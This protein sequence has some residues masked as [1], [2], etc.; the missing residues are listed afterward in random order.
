MNGLERI[1]GALNDAQVEGELWLDGSY[2]TEK[3]EPEDV[4]IVLRIRGEFYDEATPDQQAVIDLVSANLK[5]SL[6]CDSYVFV[7][8]EEPH[9]LHEDGRK[10]HDYWLRQW[11]QD[12]SGAPKGMAILTLEGG[13]P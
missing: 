3:I 6:L 2:F 1:V 10:L 9:P 11:G 5:N 13:G 8:W 7:E 12:R 4:D